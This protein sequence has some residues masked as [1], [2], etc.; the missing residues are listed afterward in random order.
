MLWVK[1]IFIC[2]LL[3]LIPVSAEAAKIDIFPGT[4]I[5]DEQTKIVTAAARKGV[6]YMKSVHHRTLN[7]DVIIKIVQ[8]RS[9]TEDDAPDKV[10]ATAKIG[11]ITIS[12]KPT[13]TP[14]YISF[15]TMHELVHQYQMEAAGTEAMDTAMWFVEGMADYIG[16]RAMDSVDRSKWN[17][18]RTSAREKAVSANFSLNSIA[19][20]AKWIKAFNSGYHVYGKAD[21]AMIYLNAHFS[22]QKQWD[23]LETLRRMPCDNALRSVYGISSSELESRMLRLNYASN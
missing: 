3:I 13:A 23:F 21:M 12:I 11:E 8:D 5:S 4:G 20:R 16:A 22:L 6:A 2:L 18:F 1:K 9:L 17:S 14:Y 10:G 15:L 19:A 7:R